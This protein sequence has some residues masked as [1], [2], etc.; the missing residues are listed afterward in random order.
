VKK[1]VSA[2]AFLSEGVSE[3]GACVCLCACV[4][5]LRSPCLR[6]YKV[7]QHAPIHGVQV[8]RRDVLGELQVGEERSDIADR[9]FV[10]CRRRKSSLMHSHRWKRL[11]WHLSQSPE[12]C[13]VQ[14]TRRNLTEFTR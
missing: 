6:L 14:G 5:S 11:R 1:F 9:P 2:S 10:Y 13:Y 8:D 12:R 3:G 7:L 4:G